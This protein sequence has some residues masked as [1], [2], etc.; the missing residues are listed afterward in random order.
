LLLGIGLASLPRRWIG[1]GLLGVMA[2][3]PWRPF[4]HR[5]SYSDLPP[6][7]DFMRLM[8]REFRAGDR[9]VVDPLLAA[10]VDSMEWFYYK[11]VYF[12]QGDFGL[13][14]A[15]DFA[16]RRL[17]YLYRQGGEDAATRNMV[18]SGRVQQTSWGPWYMHVALLEAPASDLGTPLARHCASW[19]PMSS[20]SPTSTPATFSRYGSGGRRTC[21]QRPTS[22]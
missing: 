19:E 17:W 13:M 5:P 15:E 4:D 12:P 22:Q 10:Q 6:L 16:G 7:R 2:L 3:A 18:R 9:L 20:D 8:A 11:S 1:V 14:D 21:P